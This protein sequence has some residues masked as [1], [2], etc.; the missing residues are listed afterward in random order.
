MIR[1]AATGSMQS[2]MPRNLARP[3]GWSIVVLVSAA[4]VAAAG[5]SR[6]VDAL[7]AHNA[8][9]VPGLLTRHADVN[10]RQAD[11]TTALHWAVHLDDLKTTELLIRAGARVN[12]GTGQLRCGMR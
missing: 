4:T 1:D 11:G 3:V 7:K 5:D 9:A 2:R 12:L 8:S 10:A 6:L